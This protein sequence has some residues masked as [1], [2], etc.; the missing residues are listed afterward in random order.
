VDS[1]G[2]KVTASN[3]DFSEIVKRAYEKGLTENELTIDQLMTDLKAELRNLV[4]GY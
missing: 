4:A 3:V 2:N 1:K